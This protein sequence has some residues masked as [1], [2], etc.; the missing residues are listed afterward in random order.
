MHK[1]IK[2]D[3]M[4]G[5]IGMCW[6][7]DASL[8]VS[9][10]NLSAVQYVADLIF[11]PFHGKNLALSTFLSTEL[12]KQAADNVG[13]RGRLGLGLGFFWK[14]KELFTLYSGLGFNVLPVGNPART[15]T[16]S[17][18]PAAWLQGLPQR[19]SVCRGEPACGSAPC[20]KGDG[21]QSSLSPKDSS[22]LL[23]FKDFPLKSILG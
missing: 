8:W 6:I 23:M 18:A 12:V 15:T 13:C 19:G 14:R 2:L 11:R 1:F 9:S 20:E 16:C 4:R 21:S 17:R 5:E 10:L 3:E 22:F 7:Q